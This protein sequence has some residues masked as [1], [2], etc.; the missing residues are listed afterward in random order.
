MA[1]VIVAAAEAARMLNVTPSAI[2]KM[3][4]T[5]RLTPVRTNPF[6]FALA[7]IEAMRE[8]RTGKKRGRPAHGVEIV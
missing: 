3:R 2:F 7:D 8:E 5:G 6:R 1:T 4:L